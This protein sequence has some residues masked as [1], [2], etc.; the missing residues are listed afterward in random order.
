MWSWSFPI[1]HSVF[2]SSSFRMLISNLIPIIFLVLIL[3]SSSPSFSL[4]SSS[5][6]HPYLHLN[7][8]THLFFIVYLREATVTWSWEANLYICSTRDNS[9]I[10]TV[11]CSISRDKIFIQYTECIYQFFFCKE[12][13]VSLSRVSERPLWNNH[14]W[15]FLF[16]HDEVVL[17][18]VL[19]QL[20]RKLYLRLCRRAKVVCQKSAN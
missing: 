4:F 19:R 5:P 8:H 2:L 11:K 13:F 3:I 7:A 12:S 15:L 16:G 6:T 14:D 1:L 18:V 9:L 10:K 20:F 17:N